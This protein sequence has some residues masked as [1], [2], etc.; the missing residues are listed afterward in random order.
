[1]MTNRAMQLT[2]L[3]V[4]LV[5]LFA[6]GTRFGAMLGVD[7]YVKMD[8]S[9]KAALLVAE[10]RVLRSGNGQSLVQVKEIE[11][12]GSIVSALKFQDSGMPWLFWPHGDEIDHTRMLRDVAAYR[13]QIPDVTSSVL[14]SEGG[15]DPGGLRPYATDVSRATQDLI[16]RYSR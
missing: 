14:P 1:M 15:A 4:G 11:L 10:L 3:V 13:K 9:V 2:V 16:Q 5:V 7:Q 6:A 12:D 8:S